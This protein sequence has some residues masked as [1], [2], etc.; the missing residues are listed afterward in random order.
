M[1]DKLFSNG[2]RGKSRG[3][4]LDD[5]VSHKKTHLILGFFYL[6]SKK[7]ISPLFYF[8]SFPTVTKLQIY[9]EW[10]SWEPV[11]VPSSKA[12]IWTLKQIRGPT[13]HTDEH[14]GLDCSR[15]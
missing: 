8:I 12:F 4:S 14:M 11:L 5:R 13:I 3:S 9:N 1:L 10:E 2:V 7:E 15:F 6:R